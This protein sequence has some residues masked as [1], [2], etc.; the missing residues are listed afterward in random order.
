M[1]A[2]THQILDQDLIKT[3][4]E[5]KSGRKVKALVNFSDKNNFVAYLT[6]EKQGEKYDYLLVARGAATHDQ[7]YAEYLVRMS[8]HLHRSPLEDI[9]ISGTMSEALNDAFLLNEHRKKAQLEGL[10]QNMPEYDPD[11]GSVW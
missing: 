6:P 7:W 8:T 5:D 2:V 11:N 3:S 4:Y 10:I 9:A 1:S